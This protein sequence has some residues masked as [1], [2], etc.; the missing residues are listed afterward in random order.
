MGPITLFD[1]SFLQSL[2]DDESVWF[3]HYFMPV[4]CPLFYV[5]TLADLDKDVGERRTPE[6]EVSIIARKFPEQ[7]ACPCSHHGSLAIG[8]LLGHG[9]PMNG[10]IP[11]S[12]G[13][14]V[15]SAGKV[16]V[17]YEGSLEAEA[18]ARWQQGRF[19]DIERGMARKWREGLHAIDLESIA[20]TLRE[21]GLDARTCKSLAAARE[22]A[23]SVVAGREKHFQRMELAINLLKIPREY[24]QAI[25]ERWSSIG[26]PPLIEYAPYVAH[27]VSVELFFQ[28]ALAA[29]QIGTERASNRIDI[30]YLHYLPFCMMFVSNDKLH[31]RCAPHFLRD[32]QEFV[33]GPDLKNDL[34]RINE[35]FMAFPDS[36]KE[37][38]IMA[39]AGRAPDIE[40]SVTR[41]LRSQFMSP[42]FDDQPEIEPPPKD[43]ARTR[44][45]LSMTKKWQDAPDAEVPQQ[46]SDEPEMISVARSV[47][48][49]KGSWWQ[50]S[51]DLP[52][53][54]E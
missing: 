24:H 1:K 25:V 18:F 33:W 13:R 10:Q 48:K 38:G 15:Q 23:Q 36:E 28:F 6:N 8:E 19:S 34:A 46:F 11:M 39:F 53:N 51:K 27:V 20:K 5:E 50:L 4:V 52:D 47:H 2:T 31:R 42:G 3:G 45:I 16:G 32:D 41:R 30:A 43:D 17:L 22:L 7:S 35:H 26:Y 29:H 12:G 9:V 54:V 37:R 49:K 21:I 40:G 14:A 44:E